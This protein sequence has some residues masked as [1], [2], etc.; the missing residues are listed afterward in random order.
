MLTDTRREQAEWAAAQLE[1][2]DKRHDITLVFDGVC[3][4]EVA[5]SIRNRL[6]YTV[7]C[8]GAEFGAPVDPW[9]SMVDGDF[10]SDSADLKIF[11]HDATMGALALEEIYQ[12]CKFALAFVDSSDE[13]VDISDLLSTF[14]RTLAGNTRGGR[15]AFLLSGALS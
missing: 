2:L 5:T 7:L 12:S 8:V 13:T 6:P 4:P 14:G 1:S 3:D 9:D 10:N 15:T 11:S